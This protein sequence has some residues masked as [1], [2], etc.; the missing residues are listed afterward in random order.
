MTQKVLKTANEFWFKEKRTQPI[1]GSGIDA[2]S[3]YIAAID[4]T[5]FDERDRSISLYTANTEWHP[6]TLFLSTVSQY[7][8][9][10]CEKRSA[11]IW[12]FMADIV[13]WSAPLTIPALFLN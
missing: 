6:G 12:G 3:E 11:K 2:I 8:L 1:D 7:M 13:E 10:I 9:I 4:Y 5:R